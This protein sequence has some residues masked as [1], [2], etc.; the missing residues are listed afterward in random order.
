MNEAEALNSLARMCAHDYEPLLSPDDLSD[1]LTTARRPDKNGKLP[2]EDGW[3]PT[4]DLNAA[5]AAGW[6]TKAARVASNY[7]FEEDTQVFYREQVFTHCQK[8]AARYRRGMV[9]VPYGS[10]V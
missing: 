5:A 3:E 8:M 7:R 10:E 4:W 6:D 1:L 9:Q 2:S